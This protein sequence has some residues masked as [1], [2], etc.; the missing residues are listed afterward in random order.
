VSGGRVCIVSREI[1]PW[2]RG[3]IGEA[4]RSRLDRFSEASGDPRP[5]VLLDQ[6]TRL[7][8]RVRR[9]LPEDV[10]VHGVHELAPSL[11]SRHVFRSEAYWRSYG[12]WRALETL[13]ARERPDLVEF[14]DY[15]GPGFCTIKAARLGLSPGL[16]PLV[17][18]VHGTAEWMARADGR[19]LLRIDERQMVRMERYALEHADAVIAPSA[20]LVEA[21]R[22]DY[23]LAEDVRVET[24][25]IRSPERA[26]LPTDG[27]APPHPP[28]RI[29]FLGKLQPLKGADVLVDAAVAL[30]E[31]D[32]SRRLEIH[33]VGG[34]EPGRFDPS[35]ARELRVR[36][37][38]D[39]ADHF[40]FHGALPRGRALARLAACHAAVLPS[41]M[42]TFGFAAHELARLGLPLAVSDIPAFRDAFEGDVRIERFP[43]G[44]VASLQ[45]LIEGW[46]NRLEC[47]KWPSHAALGGTTRDTTP[48]REVARDK[49]RFEHARR[50]APPG[51][52]ATRDPRVSIVLPFFEMQEYVDACLES[53]LTDEFAS[54]EIL[55]VDDGSTTP[56]ARAKIDALRSAARREPGLRVL[57]K[58]NGGLGSARNHG[59]AQARGDLVLTL[60]PDDLLLP[61]YLD[62]AVRALDHCPEL[63][64]VSC[65]S[66]LFVD[67]R[68]SERER[69][70]IVPYDPDFAML[71][72]ENGAGTAAA[73]FRRELLERHPYREDL[74]A[75]EDWDLQLRL[76]RAGV[77]GEVLPL[78]FHRYRQRADGLAR[79]GHRCHD[80]L[81]ASLL[82][83]HLAGVD[84][85]LADALGIQIAEVTRLRGIGFHALGSNA[86]LRARLAAMAERLYR[87]RLKGW[88]T[89]VLD[90]VERE[91]LAATVRAWLRGTDSN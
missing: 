30:M 38:P 13:C 68:P 22:E 90:D 45:T 84:P 28:L 76:A 81:L 26:V 11:L 2:T 19:R 32:P 42:E 66:S 29:G 27:G 61:G 85:T 53:I 25:P 50:V 70:W 64:F 5:I 35:H 15:E 69:A 9:A 7:V 59:I 57:S 87:W 36:I 79:V 65:I 16:P 55:L 71:C 58:R 20:V 14:S 3:G 47:A 89:R 77:P 6:P 24:P 46:W 62:A 23:A 18:R 31:S 80:Q 43:V 34:D 74:P 10:R 40:H 63:G 44:D 75:Y 48:R 54:R 33:L 56:A 72:L 37:P 21:L 88:L 73:V 83:P 52:R 51:P 91:R 49:R 39:L 86:G 8:R 82:A 17:V 60:D 67:G 41:R 4:L 78:V 12:I 1:A